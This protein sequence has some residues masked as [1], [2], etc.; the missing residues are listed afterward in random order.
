P[1]TAPAT[2]AAVGVADE[3]RPATAPRPGLGT[4]LEAVS[5]PVAAAVTGLVVGIVT[6]ALTT[7]A[8]AGCEAVRGTSTCGRPGFLA[9][10]AIMAAMVVLGTALLRLFRV[11]DAG[12]TSFLA[13]GLLGV[14]SLLFLVDSLLEWWMVLV[15]P[16]V[17]GVTYLFSHWV[18]TLIDPDD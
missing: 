5:G 11:G 14:V 12:S 4:A 10:L 18:T 6:V 1:T 2:A 16:L 3:P 8:L 9:L 13:I 15:I 7:L 17:T